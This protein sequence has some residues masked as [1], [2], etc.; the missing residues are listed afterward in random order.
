MVVQDANQPRSGRGGGGLLVATKYQHVHDSCVK[1]ESNWHVARIDSCAW[2][3]MFSRR[4]AGHGAER[5]LAR[6]YR[7][8]RGGSICLAGFAQ[9]TH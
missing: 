7:S 9:V 8:G 5:G 4:S 1:E 3:V 2:P 6:A